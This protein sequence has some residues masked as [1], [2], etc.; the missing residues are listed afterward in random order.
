MLRIPS[1]PK[2]S[3]LRCRNLGYARS[4]PGREVAS[5]RYLVS[6]EPGRNITKT[7]NQ[8]S[9]QKAGPSRM[10]IPIEDIC[11]SHLRGRE[12]YWAPHI[13]KH[14]AP[15]HLELHLLCVKSFEKIVEMFSVGRRKPGRDRLTAGGAPR[16]MGR[17]LWVVPGTPGMLRLGIS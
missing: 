10:H 2:Q 15:K 11:L 17:S 7:F 3:V 9:K 16:R 4:K 6:G 13:T 8:C 1:L 14:L 5:L 12:D